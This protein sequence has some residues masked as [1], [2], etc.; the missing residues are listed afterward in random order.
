MNKDTLLILI[1]EDL[2]QEI[3]DSYYLGRNSN[4]AN[5]SST[6]SLRRLREAFMLTHPL[7]T[8]PAALHES[9]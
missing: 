3:D 8:L 1:R 9:S 5:C 4:C 7:Q 2:V 6:A